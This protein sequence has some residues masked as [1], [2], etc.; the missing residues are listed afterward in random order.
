LNRLIIWLKESLPD[1]AGRQ[2]ALDAVEDVKSVKDLRNQAQHSGTD[3]RKRVT[4]ACIRLGI[5]DPI[6]NWPR[7]WEIVRARAADAFDVI[8]QEV[9][10]QPSGTG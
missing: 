5:E 1:E 7:A 2:R 6:R 4:R 3:P 10:A 9:A 8:R